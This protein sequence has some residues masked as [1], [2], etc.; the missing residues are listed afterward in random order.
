MKRASVF[1]G[2]KLIVGAVLLLLVYHH[3][4]LDDVALEF[5]R[6]RFMPLVAFTAILFANTFLSAL[7][8]KWLLEAD[9]IKLS[10]RTLFGSYLIGTFFNLF[11]PSTVGGDTYR[12]ASIGRGRIVKS[13]AAVL[14]DRL[15][16]FIAL[17][18]ICT[19]F[20]A[21]HHAV[22]GHRAIVMF[23]LLLLIAQ[24]VLSVTLLWPTKG[25]GLLLRLGFGRIPRFSSF[26]E[27]LFLSFQSYRQHP[28]LLLRILGISF[29]FQILFI[30]AIYCLSKALALS[31]PLSS[32]MVF[33]PIVAIFESIPIS[34]YGLGL[35]DAGYVFFFKQIALPSAEASALAMSVLYVVMTAGY[36]AL[37]GLTL[38]NRLLKGDSLQKLM[39]SKTPG[40]MRSAIAPA[41]DA[42]GRNPRGTED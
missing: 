27:R 5:R 3:L 16:G 25:R 24:V 14:A 11:L 34:I 22:V 10:I 15:S 2:G 20:A 26:L 19:T 17:A 40:M 23:P 4:S 7:K 37:G 21:T 13:T 41:Q 6:L 31:I 32:F 18:T 35:R 36:A 30:V 12:I 1:I 38:A 8:W 39:K 42:V 9:G 28:S 33:V 29:L